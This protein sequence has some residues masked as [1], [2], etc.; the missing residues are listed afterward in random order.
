[1]LDAR[2]G[3]IGITTAASIRGLGV[4]IPSGIAWSTAAA[5]VEH[6]GLKRGYLGLAGQPVQLGDGQ[7]EAGGP[8]EALLVV[9][10]TKGGP[11]ESAGIQVGDILTEF[12]GRAVGSPEELLDLLVAERIGRALPTRVLRG[13]TLMEVKIAVGERSR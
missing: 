8:E 10:V 7:R 6:G 13:K 2:G 12:D 3:L 9:A 11:A 4:V 5:L 1:L